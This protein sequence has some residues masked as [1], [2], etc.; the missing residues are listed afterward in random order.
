MGRFLLKVNDPMLWFTLTFSIWLSVHTGI[1]GSI[2][3]DRL[4]RGAEDVF[5]GDQHAR[6]S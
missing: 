3:G 5:K 2:E 6:F 1:I 4:R